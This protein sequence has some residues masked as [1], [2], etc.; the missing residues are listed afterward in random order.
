MMSENAKTMTFVGVGILAVIVALVTRPSS[1]ILNTNDLVNQNLT[2]KFSSPEDVKRLKIISFDEDTAT[3]REFEVAEGEG[4]LWTI[5][6]KDGYPADAT[7][8]MAEAALAL[9]DRDILR[10]ESQN[11]ADHELYGVIEPSTNLRPGQKGVGTRVS[12]FDAN[13]DPLV[14][15]IIGKE[16][17]EAEGQHYVREVG[18]DVVY[19]I[20]VDPKKLSTSFEDWIE[21]DLLKLDAWDLSQIELKD[22]SAELVAGIGPNGQFQTGIDWDRRSDMTLAYSDKDAKWEAVKLQ[23]YDPTTKQYVDFSLAED[24][25]LNTVSLNALKSALDDLKIVDVVRKPP[26]L[27]ADL[28]AGADFLNDVDAQRDLM[29]RGF[30]PTGGA[31]VDTEIISSDGEVVA[32]L[33]NGVEYVLRFGNLTSG[34]DEDKSKQTPEEKAASMNNSN[35]HRYLFAM[36]R[37]NEDAVKRPDLA[38]LPDLPKEDSAEKSEGEA[39]DR[40]ETQAA[41]KPEGEAAENPEGEATEKPEGEATEAT[42]DSAEGSEVANDAA[43]ET[44]TSAV[45]DDKSADSKDDAGDKPEVDAKQDNEAKEKD[46]EK[47]MAERKRIEDEN[48]RK[49]KEY[50]DLLAKGR[51]KVKDLNLRFGDWYFVVD[52][53]VFNKIRIGRD[54]VIKK[55]EKKDATGA[56]SASPAGNPGSSIPGLPTIPGAGK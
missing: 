4:G 27:S 29:L 40:T 5:P 54:K 47:I 2:R 50:Q 26:G 33:K 49:Q 23:A 43:K 52:N 12:L 7:Q 9:K 6:S 35:V 55:K 53:D 13:N 32:T 36:A 42:A 51:D 31:G 38:P 24:E 20:N 41:P 3:L 56:K 25:E 18:R 8:Q 30:T 15:L 39:A 11:K 45:D 44:E 21:K 37:F 14:D 48:Q 17:K 16:R 22:Y 34:P 46:V 19:V 10:I 1:A 28:K